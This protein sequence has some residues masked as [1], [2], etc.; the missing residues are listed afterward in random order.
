MRLDMSTVMQTVPG[1]WRA[2]CAGEH[3]ML[4]HWFMTLRG[5]WRRDEY[6]SLPKRL[7]GA[8]VLQRNQPCPPCECAKSQS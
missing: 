7:E 8:R 4:Q 5:Q 6:H 2:S 1:V 3:G